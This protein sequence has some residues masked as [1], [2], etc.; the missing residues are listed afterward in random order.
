ML[1]EVEAGTR[2]AVDAIVAY[3]ARWPQAA[4]T[5]HGVVQWWLPEMGVDVPLASVRTALDRLVQAQVVVGTSLPDGNV[6][7]RGAAATARP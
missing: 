1:D 5:E 3:L 6:I 7:Y 4:D 2:S